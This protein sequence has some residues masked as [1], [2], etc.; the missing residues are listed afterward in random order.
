M[1]N[2]ED[3]MLAQLPLSPGD[4]FARTHVG[5]GLTPL[6]QKQIALTR[7]NVT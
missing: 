4:Q 6:K 2:F 1:A 7:H 5:I 3:L